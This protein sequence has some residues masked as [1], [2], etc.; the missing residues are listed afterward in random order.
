MESESLPSERKEDVSKQDFWLRL[1]VISR[2]FVCTRM[3]SRQTKWFYSER[4]FLGKWVRVEGGRRN[5]YKI[6]LS[7]ENIL[8]TLKILYCSWILR[9]PNLFR[10][11]LRADAI[12]LCNSTSSTLHKCLMLRVHV[13]FFLFSFHLDNKKVFPRFLLF[14]LLFY[15]P[16]IK[17]HLP[18]GSVS[19]SRPKNTSN[20]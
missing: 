15:F 18:K 20:R 2:E 3:W 17:Q 7:Y 19:L 6:F 11:L 9:S 8:S 5:E 14:F 16:L 4:G 12:F 13:D 10:L 1:P